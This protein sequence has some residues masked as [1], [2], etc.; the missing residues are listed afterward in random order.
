MVIVNS[1]LSCFVMLLEVENFSV[2]MGSAPFLIFEKRATPFRL[3]FL[4]V[5]S[6]ICLEEVIIKLFNG[7]GERH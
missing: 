7:H 4:L 6:L 3:R 5:N 2:L 1:V